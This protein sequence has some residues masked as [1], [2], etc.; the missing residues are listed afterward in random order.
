MTEELQ[1]VLN[2]VREERVCL[3]GELEA[4]K[5]LL[6]E[7]K[8][9]RGALEEKRDEVESDDEGAGVDRYIHTLV[10]TREP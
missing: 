7:T 10:Y 5:Q 4:E 3:A 8:A 1:K 6:Q 2:A 9:I